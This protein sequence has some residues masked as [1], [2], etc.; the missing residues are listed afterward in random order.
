LWG[1]VF[2]SF[3]LAYFIYGRK[4][5]ALVPLLCGLVLMVFPYFVANTIVLVLIGV[6]LIVTPYFVRF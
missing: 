5:Q 1:L 4:Q 6:V 3:G 2:G